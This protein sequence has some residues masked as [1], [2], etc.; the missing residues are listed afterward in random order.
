MGHDPTRPAGRVGSGRIG[1]GLLNLNGDRVV[2]GQ[3]VFEISRVLLTGFPVSRDESG[4]PG[5]NRTEPHRE[6]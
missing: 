1:S 2:S 3:E 4:H 6:K 5:L